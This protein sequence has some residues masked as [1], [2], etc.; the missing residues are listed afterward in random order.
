M[1][2]S[3]TRAV[4]GGWNYLKRRGLDENAVEEGCQYEC[5]SSGEVFL[6]PKVPASL[7]LGNFSEVEKLD[8]LKLLYS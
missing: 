7:V 8:K 5:F 6:L 2:G 4:R 3:D 1:V